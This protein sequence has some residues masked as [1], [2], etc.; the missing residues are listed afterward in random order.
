[1][2]KRII[3]IVLTL[4]LVLI[5]VPFGGIRASAASEFTVSQQCLEMIKELEGFSEKPY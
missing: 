4:A 1:M 2:K 3:S 5:F